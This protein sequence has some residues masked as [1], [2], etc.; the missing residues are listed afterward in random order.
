MSNMQGQLFV[1]DPDTLSIIHCHEVGADQLLNMVYDSRQ[2]RLIGVDQGIDRRD[3]RNNHLGRDY[4]A[5]SSGHE[6]LYL[7]RIQL[8][9]SPGCRRMKYLSVWHGMMNKNDFM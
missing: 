1:V 9:L 6:V 7:M 2:N 4:I 5:R 3:W 8:K